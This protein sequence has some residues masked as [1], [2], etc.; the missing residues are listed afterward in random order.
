MI[1]V[2]LVDDESYVTE[3]LAAT[4]P[5]RELGV[6]RVYQAASPVEALTLLEEQA[7]DILVRIFVCRK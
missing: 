4:I 5:W 6:A 3:S 2:L 7:I 1:E